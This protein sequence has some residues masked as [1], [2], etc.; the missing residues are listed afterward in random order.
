MK[1]VFFFLLTILALQTM[2]AQPTG[3]ITGNVANVVCKPILFKYLGEFRTPNNQVEI[4]WQAIGQVQNMGNATFN[5][6]NAHLGLAVV[7]TNTKVSEK[8]LSLKPGIIAQVELEVRYLKGQPK[9]NMS[10]TWVVD[11]NL[12][13][14][15]NKE[16]PTWVPN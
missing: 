3:V 4:R 9:P 8:V 11:G 5:S 6:A 12:E 10:L 1:K 7:N 14:Y 13:C 2:S 16:V 15:K